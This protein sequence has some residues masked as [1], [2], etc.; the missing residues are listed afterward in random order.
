MNL[1]KFDAQFEI[2]INF[3]HKSCYFKFK[4][5]H[6]FQTVFRF[7]NIVVLSRANSYDFDSYSRG[8]WKPL[9]TQDQTSA[10]CMDQIL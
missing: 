8:N 9:R 3:I 7:C 1:I 2:H 10:A 4:S 6:L 5:S